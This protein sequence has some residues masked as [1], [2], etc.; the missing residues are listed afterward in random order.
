MN[1]Q[2]KELTERYLN[3][4]LHDKGIK[5]SDHILIDMITNLD[6]RIRSLESNQDSKPDDN[7]P[8]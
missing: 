3:N 6:S 2:L 8:F 1:Q 5:Y 4:K 7:N